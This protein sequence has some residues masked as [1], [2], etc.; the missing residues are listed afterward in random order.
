MAELADPRRGP[1]HGERPGADAPDR[2][3]L[4]ELTPGD[5]AF[6]AS[7]EDI[8]EDYRAE[9]RHDSWRDPLLS[10]SHADVPAES[11]SWAE[12][13]DTWL[14]DRPRWTDPGWSEAPLRPEVRNLVTLPVGPEMV[15]CLAVL[16]VQGLCDTHAAEGPSGRPGNPCACQIVVAAAWAAVASWSEARGARALAAAA[17]LK[18]VDV[19]IDPQR[20]GLG[21][22]VDPAVE[23]LAPA[24]RLSPRSAQLRI[25][26]SRALMDNP[27]LVGACEAGVITTWA[28][29]LVTSDL[30]DL[31]PVERDLVADA[32]VEKLTA[33]CDQG[34][35]NWTTTQIRAAAKRISLAVGFDLRRAREQARRRRRVVV[36]DQGM[37]MATL[38]AELPHEVAHRI[39]RRI[40]EL[41]SLMGRDERS[42]DEQRADV[43]ADLLLASPDQSLSDPDASHAT[44]PDPTAPDSPGPVAGHGGTDHRR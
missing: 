10:D 14:A 25:Q 29:R 1:D 8:Y 32:L 4:T 2:H 33:R 6:F 39:Y 9:L 43:F 42:R 26:S 3:A 21:S 31:T 30:A 20:P 37:G 44:A 15:A 23:Q 18:P 34:L 12:S 28:A 41:A 5:L 11:P 24:L 27:L 13:R 40:S 16:P 19:P 22:V 38:I 36:Q 7:L 17:G 35:R